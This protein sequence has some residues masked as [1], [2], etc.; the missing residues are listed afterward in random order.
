MLSIIGLAYNIAIPCT[1]AMFD[2][3]LVLDTAIVM[4]IKHVSSLLTEYIPMQHA[5]PPI[6]LT[7]GLLTFLITCA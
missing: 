4:A 3:L 1:Y 6:R 7:L 5:I 2:R